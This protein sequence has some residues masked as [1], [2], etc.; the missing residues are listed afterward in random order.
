MS[1]SLI[2][3]IVAVILF[4]FAA[5]GVNIPPNPLAWGLVAF[6]AAHLPIK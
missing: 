6:A 4:V 3:T 2:F 5:L 1:T